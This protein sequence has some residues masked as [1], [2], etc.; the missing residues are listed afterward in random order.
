MENETVVVAKF[1]GSS[2]ADSEQIRKVADIV[3]SDKNRKFVVVSAPGKRHGKDQKITDLLYLC[4]NMAEQDLEFEEIFKVI[5]TRYKGIRDELGLSLE[6]EKQLEEI[7]DRIANGATPDYTA[8]RGEYLNGILI[9][10]YLDY[11]FI[12]AAELVVFKRNGVCDLES[13]KLKIKE[14][15]EGC[16]RAVIPGFYGATT[17]GRIRTFSRGGSDVTGSL[18]AQ[19]VEADLYE[20]W[21]D[22]SGFLMADPRIVENPRPIKLLTYKELRELSYMGATVLHE[23]ATYPVRLAGIKMNIKNTNEPEHP[24]TLIMDDD[25]APHI[26]GIITGIAGKKDFSV[27]SVDKPMMAGEVGFVRKLLSIMEMNDVSVEH[28]PTG[29]DSVSL[30]VADS[31]IEN[32]W[33]SLLEEI[34]IQCEPDSVVLNPNMALM[35]VVG[36]GMIRSKGI[37]AK[38]FGALYKSDINVRMITQGAGELNIIV[39]VENEDFEK[40]IKAVYEAFVQ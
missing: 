21:T 11:E 17:D 27:I 16:R 33:E 24:G 22:V 30:V 26:E 18:I 14:R 25:Q 35:A 40:G 31:E 4:H 9:A 28:F 39:G 3:R 12:D 8:S 20:N 15:T 10:D 13:T 34:K 5:E 37:S 32:K 29:I 19:G 23:D 36:R 6:I 7:K 38:L 1:G 2:L